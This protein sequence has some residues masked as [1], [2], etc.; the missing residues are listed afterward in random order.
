MGTRFVQS[1]VS[2]LYV[3]WVNSAYQMFY[4]SSNCI[5]YTASCCLQSMCGRASGAGGSMGRDPYNLLLQ[6]RTLY[7]LFCASF[8]CYL[9]PVGCGTRV[10]TSHEIQRHCSVQS[11]K[12]L[13]PLRW[14]QVVLHLTVHQS[15]QGV[16]TG[17]DSCDIMGGAQPHQPPIISPPEQ[18]HFR[19]GQSEIQFENFVM[20]L[21]GRKKY[22]LSLRI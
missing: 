19:N 13:Q 14:Q 17:A 9:Q 11:L 6:G 20:C 15:H 22:Q 12:Q 7:S 2:W 4:C 8:L 10:C 21:H 16:Y 1:P 3:T 18:F 5:L